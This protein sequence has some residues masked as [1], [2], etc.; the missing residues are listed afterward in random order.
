MQRNLKLN[1]IVSLKVYC[2]DKR[3]VSDHKI[4]KFKMV[5]NNFG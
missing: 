4:V 1:Y 2:V 3:L 5:I